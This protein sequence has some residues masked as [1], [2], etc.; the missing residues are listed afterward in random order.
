M[1]VP[2]VV[3]GSYRFFKGLQTLSPFRPPQTGARLAQGRPTSGQVGCITSPT[4]IAAFHDVVIRHFV[5]VNLNLRVTSHLQSLEE[6]RFTFLDFDPELEGPLYPSALFAAEFSDVSENL[7]TGSQS[8]IAP[9]PP[10]TGTFEAHLDAMPRRAWSPI[11]FR[12][13]RVCVKYRIELFD[14]NHDVCTKTV[15]ARVQPSSDTMQDGDCDLL[16]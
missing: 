8:T 3:L 5:H 13:R 16:S 10:P 4:S 6:S 1:Q 12:G 11:A 14:G 2:S 9:P 7:T 15:Q